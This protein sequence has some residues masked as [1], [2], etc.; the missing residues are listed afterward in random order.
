MERGVMIA[1]D[2]KLQFLIPV[3]H[4]FYQRVMNLP[5]AFVDLGVDERNAAYCRHHFHYIS[6][7]G[8]GVIPH[9]KAG[10]WQPAKIHDIERREAWFKKPLACR[11]TP[12]QR[13]FW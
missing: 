7:A 1:A 8:D 4:G 12:F 6:L 10:V 9:E 13:T 3:W 11:L 5:V 2:R